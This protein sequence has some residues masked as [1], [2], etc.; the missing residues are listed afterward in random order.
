MVL[1]VENRVDLRSLQEN[2]QIVKMGVVIKEAPRKLPRLLVHGVPSAMTAAELEEEFWSCNCLDFKKELRADAFKPIHKTG[3]KNLSE[4]KWVVEVSQ[5]VRPHLIGSGRLRLGWLFCRVVDHVSVSRCYQCQKF[6]HIAR[7]CNRKE[8]CGWCA[9]EGHNI[10]NCTRK[11]QT[12]VCINCKEARRGCGHDA[13]SLECPA[14]RI[15]ME[16]Q[17]RLTDYGKDE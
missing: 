13:G 8:V 12:A 2:P 5:A 15:A 3:P 1:E 6:G 17:V 10:K 16:N 9:E 14:Y 7:G 4:T 11:G